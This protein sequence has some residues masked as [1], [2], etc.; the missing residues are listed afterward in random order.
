MHRKRFRLQVL[1]T[2]RKVQRPIDPTVYH[3]ITYSVYREVGSFSRLENLLIKNKL[4]KACKATV[5]RY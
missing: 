2:E 1:H 3:M 4:I 5:I